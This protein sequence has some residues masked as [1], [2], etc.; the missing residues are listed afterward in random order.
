LDEDIE[1]VL[2]KWELSCEELVEPEEGQLE[3]YAALLVTA[4]PDGRMGCTG[5]LEPVYTG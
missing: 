3:S 1:G 2:W 4:K 5:E